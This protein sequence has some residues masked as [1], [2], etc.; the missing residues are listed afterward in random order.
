MSV[1]DRLLALFVVVAWGLNFVVIKVGLYGMPPFLLAGLRFALVMFPAILFVKPPNI[2]LRWMLAYG[3]TISFGQF[4][5]LFMAI[6]LGMPAVWHHWC[7][8]LR[9]SL[10]FCSARCCGRKAEMG[11]IL[12]GL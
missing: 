1:K 10:P 6:K 8:R 4:A 2:P 11:T 7:C 9:L 3:I 12:P 5:F